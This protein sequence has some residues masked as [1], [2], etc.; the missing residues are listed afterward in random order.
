MGIF[1]AK[2][3]L[4]GIAMKT[5]YVDT[6]MTRPG[7]DANRERARVEMMVIKTK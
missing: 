6:R 7:G 5:N 2:D 1:Y 4:V 3:V